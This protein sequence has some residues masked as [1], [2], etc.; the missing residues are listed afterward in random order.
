MTA[1]Y[2][3]L[4]AC[5]VFEVTWPE[6]I[7]ATTT[8]WIKNM[9]AAVWTMPVDTLVSVEAD[10]EELSDVTIH[11]AAA[12]FLVNRLCLTVH[13]VSAVWAGVM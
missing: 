2:R 9:N 12:T 1:N 11:S 10:T 6:T 7:D 4:S 3:S 8:A 5:L 13:C